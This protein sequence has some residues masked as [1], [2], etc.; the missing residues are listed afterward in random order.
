MDKKDLKIVFFGTPEFAVASLDKLVEG[1]YNVAAVVTMPDKQAGRGHHMIQSDV[2]KYAL[3]KGLR[4][5]QPERLKDETFVS[6]LKEINADLFIVI[7]FRMLP[8][9]V[10]GMPRLGTFNLHASL[11]PKYRG[12][13]PIQ[14][15]V[16]D[17]D[18]E[19][20]VTIMQMDEGLDTGDM[21]MVQKYTLDAK[22]TGGSLFDKLSQ[23]GGPM[24]LEVLKQAEAGELHP[25]PQ[26]EEYTYAKMLSKETGKLDFTRPA[27]ELER[28]IRGL[29][30]WPSCYTGLQGKMLKIWDADIV[31]AGQQAA[32][33][34]EKGRC[35]QIVLIDKNRLWIQTGD[36]CLSVQSLQLAGKKRMNIADF[37]RGMQI[38]CGTILACD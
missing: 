7:A 27:V 17:G 29:N 28:L 4:I 32:E 15:S 34:I 31:D 38:D 14:W 25:V 16:I 37:L 23:L 3:E 18:P 8:E 13:A 26:G 24:I 21:L 35:G 30:P 5:L 2:K 33:Q 22:E 9:V 11:L 1:G 6:Q 10:W 12:A 20:G 19:S 36:G